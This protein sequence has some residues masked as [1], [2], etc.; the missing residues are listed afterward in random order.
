M[1][2]VFMRVVA[3][4]FS[5]TLA[6]QKQPHT[7]SSHL[8]F[9][10]RTQTG[11][12]TFH[13]RDVKL[14]RQ[15]STVHVTL[16]QNGREEVLGY[17]TNS[18]IHKE[19][20]LTLET[21]Y[22]LH[23]APTPVDLVKLRADQDELWAFQPYKLF[24][25]FRKASNKVHFFFPRQGQHHPSMVDE[26]MRFANGEKF[27][28]E[29]LGYVADMFPQ[30][31]ESYVQADSYHVKGGVLPKQDT[32]E[33][34]SN[35]QGAAKY[36]YPTMLLNLDVKKALPAEGVEWLFLRVRTKSIKNGRLDLE[37]IILDEMGE[38]V[39]L[40]H[41]VC[42]ILSSERNLAARQKPEANA[43]TSRL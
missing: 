3:A 11:E 38:I 37:I 9:L 26:W 8:E 14:G 1:T 23:P 34:K 36:W 7:I 19:S 17:F 41:H 13:V 42:L 43:D 5:T 12:A 31:V 29:S 2:A 28:N 20:G 24:P 10:R 4:H 21:D 33:R 15:T 35:N 6:K 40:S 18:D 16:V 25:R 30:L 27:T 22:A 32:E 39:A